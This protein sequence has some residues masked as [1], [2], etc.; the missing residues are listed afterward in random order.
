M[1]LR[2]RRYVMDDDLNHPPE[3]NEGDA[4]L[5]SAPAHTP[6]PSR[7]ALPECSRLEAARAKATRAI[8]V[9]ARD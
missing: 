9:R 8:Q 6:G 5:P 7:A 2:R 3:S 1:Q 4:V